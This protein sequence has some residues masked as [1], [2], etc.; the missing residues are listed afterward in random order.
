MTSDADSASSA[1]AANRARFPY[2]AE[3]LDHLRSL[4]GPGCRLL[5]A[6]QGADSIGERQLVGVIATQPAR[7]ACA[8]ASPALASR[9]R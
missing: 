4:F 3:R 8:P 2:A 7:E 1:R 6:T 9:S 5:H